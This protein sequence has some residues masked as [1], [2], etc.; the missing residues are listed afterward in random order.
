MSSALMVP[1]MAVIANLLAVIGASMVGIAITRGTKN[2]WR[3]IIVGLGYLA[4]GLMI[5]SWGPGKTMAWGL[6]AVTVFIFAARHWPL[7][8]CLL[9]GGFGALDLDA[10]AH[11]LPV[12]LRITGPSAGAF[13]SV[14]AI[15]PMADGGFA[16]LDRLDATVWLFDS[17]GEEVIALGGEGEG[18]G[19]LS[20]QTA[21]VLATNDD[22]ILV[23]DLGNR[24]ITV[25]DR[26]G[27]LE[28]TLPL[29]V[30]AGLPVAWAMSGNDI[31]IYVAPPPTASFA[32]F[33]PV[34]R[35]PVLVRMALTGEPA[36]T[37]A[38]LDL[39]RPVVAESATSVT[40]Q[41]TPVIPFLQGTSQ[42]KALFAT[43]AA[44]RV[45][46]LSTPGHPLSVIRGTHRAPRASRADREY[47]TRQFQQG[48]KAS[49]LPRD[50]R[51]RII[52]G[53]VPPDSLPML[54]GLVVGEDILLLKP[55]PGLR[56]SPIDGSSRL[57]LPSAARWWV[58]G[59]DGEELGEV[60]LPPR[61]LPLA[62]GGGRLLGVELGEFDEPSVVALAL[63]DR[64]STIPGESR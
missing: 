41:A 32:A 56:E 14:A 17:D 12:V 39:K 7:G 53:L 55:G 59:L 61:F 11:Q 10:Q 9:L 47:L 54:A 45:D 63:P 2:R 64:W 8:V 62:V 23:G 29:D 49:G 5:V 20:K 40:V 3:T 28:S 30:V 50:I 26:S 60:A 18:P 24:R 25:W 36:D 46:D 21:T 44:F 15:A 13:A 58:F 57:A 51:S 33:R 38:R 35:Q 16:V 43:S 6:L 42:G 52:D 31:L 27:K 48:L 1:A 19:R 4:G 22:R 34:V 37:I